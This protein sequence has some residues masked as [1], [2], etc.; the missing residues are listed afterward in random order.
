MAGIVQNFLW[1]GIGGAIGSMS[2]YGI[3]LLFRHWGWEHFPIGTIAVNI[4]GSICIGVFYALAARNIPVEHIKPFV[5]IG[6]LGGFTTFSSYI[7]DTFLLIE[8]NALYSA[9]IYFVGTLI[10]GFLGFI[11]GYKFFIKII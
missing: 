11:L 1:V 10:I 4:I 9:L 7:S 6:I 5:V 3:Y 8:K 2:R